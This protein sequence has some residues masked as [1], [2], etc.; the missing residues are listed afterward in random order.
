[1]AGVAETLGVARVIEVSPVPDTVD[2][3]PRLLRIL[4]AAL[5]RENGRDDVVAQRVKWCAEVLEGRTMTDPE[6]NTKLG[7]LLSKERRVKKIIRT[8]AEKFE[9]EAKAQKD[10]QLS[11]EDE[12]A[13]LRM[14]EQ[15]IYGDADA[16]TEDG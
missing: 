16:E 11:P 3:A 13:R 15:G 4:A 8:G 6:A 7:R 1:V 2:P 9:V 5:A 14:R 10:A 12:R